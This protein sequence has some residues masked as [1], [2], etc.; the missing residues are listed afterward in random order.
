MKVYKCIWIAI[1]GLLFSACAMNP[2]AE[3]GSGRMITE[4]RPVSGI[5][6]VSLA[7]EGELF[8]EMGNAESL[9]IEAE[10]NL[11]PRIQTE[12]R[13]GLLTIQ[14]Q[15]T[16]N[17]FFTQP[18]RYYLTV[19]NLSSISISSSGDIHAPDLKS[20]RFS[21]NVSSSGNLKMGNLHTEDLSV[22]ISSSGDVTMGVLNAGLID[23]N[24]SSSGNLT[25]GGGEAKRQ[26]I[27]SSSSGDYRAQNLAS[28]EAVVELSSSG[29]ADIR[30]RD[31]L[32]AALSSSGDV[33]YW[34]NPSV[35][36]N[37]SSSGDLIRRGN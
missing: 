8:I 25:I 28:D 14:T 23:V 7:A 15:T 11:I 16:S 20:D 29:N 19:K 13:D 30:A 3:R 27:E 21:I 37:K 9:R 31:R 36:I 10:D 33:R 32:S 1:F 26:N 2:Y 24:I 17:V 5:S 34:G 18:V 12:V 22:N 4:Q 6:G 35:N